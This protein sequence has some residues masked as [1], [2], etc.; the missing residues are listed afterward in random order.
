MKDLIEKIKDYSLEEIMGDR[1]G[2]YSKYIIQERAIPDVRDGLKP[3]QRR[4][5]YSMYKERNTYD[6]PYLKSARAVGD[7]MGK[8]HPHGDSSIYDAMVRMSQYWKIKNMLVDMHG[9]NGSIDGDSPAAPRYTEARL[10]K[11]SNELLRD[12]EKDTVIFAP[13]Y[14]DKLFE[15]TVLPAKFPNLLVNGS[16]GI[17]AGYATNIPP[18]NLGEVIDATIKRIDN[19][20]CRIDSILDIVK[21]PDFPTGGIVEGT[22]GIKEAYQTGRG[23]IYIKAKTRIEKNKGKLQIIIDEIPYEVNKTNLVKKM[24]DIRIDKKID[25]IADVRDESDQEGLRI[26]VD[27][28]KEANS[29]LI[30]NYLLKNTDLHISYNFNVVAIVNR[31]P[32]L[33][34][35][36]EILDAYI[37]HQKEV[38]TKRSKFDLEHAEN[39]LHITEGVIK[40]L[41]ILDDIIK[42]IRSS[43]DKKDAEIN[44][45]KQ[46][47]FT[48]IQANAIVM[49]Q[50]YKLTNTDVTELEQRL[51]RLSFIIKG[52]KAILNDENRLKNVIKEELRKIK[53]EYNLMRLTEI[54][55]EVTEIK[56]DT[57]LMIPKEEVIVVV[58]KEGYIK[59]V[60][61][62]SYAASCHEPTLLKELDYTIGLFTM[63]TVDTLLMFTN[64]GNYLYIPVHEIP[65]TKWKELGKHISNI[66]TIKAEEVIIGCM[67]VYNFEDNID[68]TTFTKLG[69]VKRTSLGE[70]KATRHSKPMGAIKLKTNDEVVAVSYSNFQEVLIVTYNGYGLWYDIKEIPVTGLR[71]SGVKAIS[72]KDDHVIDATIFNV[73]HE[74]ITLITN[75]GTGKRL[76]I[77]DLG[78]TSRNRRGTL[79]IRVVKT[80]PYHLLKIFMVEP[81]KIIG[82]R[83]LNDIKHLKISDLTIMDRHSTGNGIVK[84]EIKDAFVVSDLISDK[85]INNSEVKEKEETSLKEID[86]KILTIDDF[87]DEI[88]L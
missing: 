77:A 32:K 69:M 52:L 76:R 65:D 70:Y 48:E 3:V 36:L 82:I 44:L 25:G 5:L 68:I 57:N 40:A 42:T 80:N 20:N 86:N 22:E 87:L 33:L 54:H 79:L 49:M 18:H 50:L 83:T 30:L 23:K 41:S 2:R 53:K 73:A 17:S 51:E 24:D 58:S 27:I 85:K 61:N 13:N 9:N 26:V 43:K 63:N 34:G 7:I 47:Q 4:I 31:R 60:S 81:K 21:G 10:A 45:M 35:I 38:I 12:I 67:P 46:Y 8:Y 78:K 71:T 59:R 64:L 75:K 62:R 88:D 19:P 66:I 37:E 55:E 11:I 6:K 56:L 1:F 39:Q 28:K 29:D 84:G 72:L 15:P 74:Y 16:S 14:D